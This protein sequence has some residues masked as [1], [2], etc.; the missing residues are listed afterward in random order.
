MG[1]FSSKRTVLPIPQR[2]NLAQRPRIGVLERWPDGTLYEAWPR[3]EEPALM[4]DELRGREVTTKAI[5][6]DRRVL[7]LGMPGAWT[8]NCHNTHLPAYVKHAGE[9]YDAGVDSI[10]IIVTNDV[11]CAR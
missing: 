6:K 4:P 1:N 11:F 9:F 2:P 3:G 7:V 8:P 10:V 5:L